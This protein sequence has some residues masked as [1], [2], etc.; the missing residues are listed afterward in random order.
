MYFRLRTRDRANQG[1][2]G[3]GM[4]NRPTPTWYDDA[5]LGIFVHWGLYSVPGW[6]YTSGTLDDVPNR[7]GW[8]VWFRDNAYAEWYANSL[9]IPD[10]P[11]ASY[12]RANYGDT[13]YYDFIPMFNEAIQLWDP[14]GWAELFK[15]AGA[16]Y[17]ILTT[18][19]HDG[20][21]LWPSQE[22]HPTLGNFIASRDIVG[23]LAK[24]VRDADMRF[25]TYYS[26]GL[27]WS[28]NPKPIMD[29]ADLG[30]TVIQDP[31]YVAYADAQWRELMDR[32]DT[33]ILWNDIA[34]PRNSELEAIVADFYTRTT[35]GL[36]NDRFRD[37]RGDGSFTYLTQPDM[38]TPEYTS[39]AE[40]R[41]EKWEANR[42]I[43]FSF[44]Y[45]HAEDETN[46]IPIE[47]LIRFFVDIVSKN[48]N[49][50]LNVGPRAD[51]SI[52]DG[53]LERVR[54]LGKWL[55]VNGDAI[56]GTR[57][58]EVAE[59]STDAGIDVRFTRKGNAL[60]AFLLGQPQ[61]GAI[62]INGLQASPKTNVSMLGHDAPLPSGAGSEGLVVTLP[63]SLAAS[64]AHALRIEPAPAWAG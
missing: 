62:R 47:T 14:A 59:G 32:Y 63:D 24:A 42:G 27:D 48:G 31:T 33:S 45:N 6:A 37:Y 30:K 60:F 44:G 61:P 15:S 12:H 56:Y 4:S 16:G 8:Q 25:G 58:W 53:Q 26:G 52:Q 23:E 28:V 17:V 7:L 19:H 55:A 35:D 38:L 18:K 10:S 49:M 34:Y 51:G 40:T 3:S 41:A 29:I 9:K 50:L 5:K 64:P 21:C 46:F 57:P 36:V 11:T 43:G 54:A 1:A 22:P 2:D 13:G 20:F 39:F